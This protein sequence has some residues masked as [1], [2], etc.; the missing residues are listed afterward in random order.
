VH[1]RHRPFELSD[2]LAASLL[3][4]RGGTVGAHASRRVLG[5]VT[6]DRLLF[7]Q[8]E[9]GLLATRVVQGDPC[10]SFPVALGVAR[11]ELS[12]PRSH[13]RVDLVGGQ[14]P[15]AGLGPRPLLEDRRCLLVL[16]RSV[17]LHPGVPGRVAVDFEHQR[18]GTP[19]LLT[20]GG[21]SRLGLPQQAINLDDLAARDRSG[22]CRIGWDHQ[23]VSSP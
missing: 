9:P 3:G 11:L 21:R 13:P 16:L 23:I 1:C 7:Q 8:C 2:L 22:V 15:E 6:K 17:P 19:E 12:I 10:S 18:P 14:L 5:V 20:R 4:H